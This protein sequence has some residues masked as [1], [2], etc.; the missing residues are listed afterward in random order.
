MTKQET[1][2]AALS[3]LPPPLRIQILNVAAETEVQLF[4]PDS[5]GKFAQLNLLRKR[6]E[7]LA[8]S[9]RPYLSLGLSA[10]TP[11]TTPLSEDILVGVGYGLL[12]VAGVACF[13]ALALPFAAGV[14]S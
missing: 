8:R 3:R 7:R 1:F 5:P 12:C 14:I 9:A 6:T 4:R 2:R 11:R 13:G 10:R